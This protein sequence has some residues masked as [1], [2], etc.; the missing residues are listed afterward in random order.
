MKIESNK[1]LKALNSFGIDVCADRYLSIENEKELLAF[2]SENDR[3]SYLPLGGGSNV[4]FTQNSTKTVL[5][6]GIKGIQT[7]KV[8]GI[9]S[10]IS[11][12]AGENWHSFVLWC[13]ENN[14]GGVENLSLIPGNV[15]TAPIQNIGAYGV[16][17]KDVFYS[18]KAL[19][20]KNLEIE[21]IF[22]EEASF[23]YRN[24]IFKSRA[25]GKYIITEVTFKLRNQ[26]H[27]LKTAYGAIQNQLKSKEISTPTIQDISDAIIEIRQQKLPNPEEIGNAGSFFKNPIVQKELFTSI[28]KQYPD[29]PFY[30]IDE[31]TIKIPAGW[32]IETLGYKGIKRGNYG[33]HKNQAL[34]LVNYGG[35]DGAAIYALAKEIQEKV[36]E[37]FKIPLEM[38]VNIL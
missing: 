3:D 26:E 2:C 36:A 22:L 18:C 9:H 14:L 29:M 6:I 20:T 4:L 13:I 32:I 5:Q 33:V 24:S 27:L 31:E 38:E 37:K 12:G 30:P 1:S 19:N 25:K 10:Y 34:V 11:V 8:E 17:I 15:G 35:A 7:T 23:G 28:Q 21:T 16:E